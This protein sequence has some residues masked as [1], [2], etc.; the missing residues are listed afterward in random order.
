VPPHVEWLT[1]PIDYPGSLTLALL[2]LAGL[3]AFADLQGIKK[4]G[5]GFV[6]WAA[7]LG[8]ALVIWHCAPRL[9]PDSWLASPWLRLY[10]PRV[11]VVVLGAL[12]GGTLFGLYLLVSL[13]VL[14]IHTNDAFA[15][16][17]IPHY[18]HFLRCQVTA[19]GLRISVIGVKRVATDTQ[20]HPVETQLIEVV[21]IH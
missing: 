3:W 5:W 20:A 16:L 1:Y 17:R 8:M 4:L 14:K 11:S 15:A 18:K 13:N 12:M 9:W 6:H 2:F 21:N 10:L 7:H 19:E